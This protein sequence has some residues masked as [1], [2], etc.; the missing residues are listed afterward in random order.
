MNIETIITLAATGLA[1]L[2]A[3][4]VYLW[5]SVMARLDNLETE[6]KKK[7]SEEDVRQVIND[8]IEPI[9]DKCD[10]IK[11]SI[12]QILEHILAKRK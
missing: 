6:M 11:A 9:N 12:N 7:I 2:T 8:K 3:P 10:D 4:L 5:R 1:V